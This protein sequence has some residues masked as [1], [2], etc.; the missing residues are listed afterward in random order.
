VESLW[1]FAFITASLVYLATVG[2]LWWAAHARA[3]ASARR[4]AAR[5][6]ERRMT[7]GVTLAVGATVVILLVFLVTDLSVGRTLD[8]VP[9]K[10]PLTIEVTGHSGG[11]T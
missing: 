5:D 3:A 4:G 6:G 8:P 1:W 9:R 10:H 2:A 7:R 11:G